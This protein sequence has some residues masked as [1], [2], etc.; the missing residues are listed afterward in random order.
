MSSS[1]EARALDGASIVA[2]DSRCTAALKVSWPCMRMTCSSCVA[3]IDGGAEAV[4]VAA[5]CGRSGRGRR[6]RRTTT[7]PAPSANRAAVPRSR[8]STKRLITSAP[9]T[10]TLLAAAGLDLRGGERERR[11]EA[12]AG[13]ADVHRAGA[14]R[15]ELVRHERRGVRAVSS[16]AAMVAT[17]TRSSSAASTPA[18]S[19]AAPAGGHGEIA[20][21]LAFGARGGARG[22]PCG[23][24][25]TARS[26][27]RARPPSRWRRRC[28]ARP[29]PTDASGGR[30]RW[31]SRGTAGSLCHAAGRARRSA[32]RPPSRP[33]AD[34]SAST[35]S[36]RLAHEAVSTLARARSR[37][38]ASAPAP[39]ARASSRASAPGSVERLARAARADVVERLRR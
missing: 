6:R 29:S 20:Q 11:E 10:S 38:S 4:G 39:R 5:R 27:R 7:A 15:A 8:V 32:H 17:S 28:P 23:G 21:A 33:A 30:A 13:G 2:S 19:S 35:P 9:I 37:R 24:R 26:R 22:R 36:M 18:S 1:V 31:R 12:G 25:S 14:V 3:Q 34:A 16:S